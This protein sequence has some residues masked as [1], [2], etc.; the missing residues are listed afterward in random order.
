MAD[1][2]EQRNQH[3][4]SDYGSPPITVRPAA[5]QTRRRTAG[6]GPRSRLRPNVDGGSRIHYEE[7]RP[8]QLMIA[9]QWVRSLT[10][11]CKA[12]TGA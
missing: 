5:G 12:L 7:L 8:G 1:Q 9:D 3:H 2:S 10:T 6:R 4:P 11:G